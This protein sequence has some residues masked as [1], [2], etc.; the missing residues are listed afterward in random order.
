LA[1]H[2]L[3]E[4]IEGVEGV[5]GVKDGERIRDRE[6]RILCRRKRMEAMPWSAGER[7]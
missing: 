4:E 6:K 2:A 3:G 5:E 1:W 7:H